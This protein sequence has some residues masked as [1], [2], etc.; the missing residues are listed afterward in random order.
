[1]KR[2]F[3]TITNKETNLIEDE[4]EVWALDL[5]SAIEKARKQAKEK[6]FKNHKTHVVYDSESFKSFC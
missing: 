2:Y 5:T 3:A 6:G 1:M 4:F